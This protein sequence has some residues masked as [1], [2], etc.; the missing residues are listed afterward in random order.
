MG[1]FNDILDSN[2]YIVTISARY[3]GAASWLT[4]TTA[5]VTYVHPCSL[6]TILVQHHPPIS[7]SL[8]VAASSSSDIWYDSFTGSPSASRKC[9]DFSIAVSKTTKPASYVDAT[10]GGDFTWTTL[11]PQTQLSV[12]PQNLPIG[13]YVLTF[14]ICLINYPSI[15]NQFG[16]S[17]TI[18]ACVVT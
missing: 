1:A 7:T 9:G 3:V 8:L 18:T 6:A 17:V 13:S 10:M 12:N 2:A 5:T 11:S 4:S 14:D 16:S 15:C